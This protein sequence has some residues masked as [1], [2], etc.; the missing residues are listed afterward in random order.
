MRIS[1]GAKRLNLTIVNKGSG[2]YELIDLFTTQDG[3][4][5]PSSKPFSVPSWAL[6]Y[7]PGFTSAGAATHALVRVE[8]ANRKPITIDVKFG[9]IVVSTAG[10]PEMW[11]VQQINGSYKPEQGEHGWWSIDF[12]GALHR[13]EGIG[14]PLNN[15]VS[16]FA[17]YR[18]VQPPRPDGGKIEIPVEALRKA[19]NAARELVSA[20]EA[21]G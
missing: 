3:S 7:L 1:E 9:N 5:E 18:Q 15:H 4:W 21:L 12:D 19:Q 6:V 14:L 13:I 17:V 11:A 2:V 20:L 16:I 10:K 8:D